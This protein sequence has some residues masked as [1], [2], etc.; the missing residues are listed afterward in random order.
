[1]IKSKGKAIL[2][3][4]FLMII[5]VV[6]GFSAM[7]GIAFADSNSRLFEPLRTK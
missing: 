2:V 3:L 7:T 4:I 5:S 6:A 1:M